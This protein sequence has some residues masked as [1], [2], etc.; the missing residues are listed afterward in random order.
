MTSIVEDVFVVQA[1]ER[2]ELAA[3][4]SE[5]PGGREVIDWFG[6]ITDFGDSEVIRL[7]LDRQGPSQLVI[8]LDWPTKSAIVTFELSA[9]IDVTLR[10]FSHQNVIGGLRLRRPEDREVDLWEQ[11]VGLEPGEWMIELSPCFGACGKIRANIA[12]IV[13]G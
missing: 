3:A 6:D 5:I 9:W 12:R 7:T 13:I 1:R 4:L 2:N 8:A 10:G 11:G